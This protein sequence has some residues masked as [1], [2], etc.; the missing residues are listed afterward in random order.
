MTPR[1]SRARA[2]PILVVLLLAAAAATAGCGGSSSGSGPSD[3][4]RTTAYAK[5]V[6]AFCTDVNAATKRFQRAAAAL[7]SETDRNVAARRFGAALGRLA[8]GFGE[9][10]DR[11]RDADPPTRFRTSMRQ[12]VEAL[13]ESETRLRTAART[14]RSGDAASLKRIASSLGDLRV[15]Q[16]P[17]ELLDQAPACAGGGA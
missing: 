6:D 1:P 11:L 5:D 15:P 16:A 12:A 4:A 9:G 13:D 7:G 8:D 17:A 10:A 2:R 3:G 14:A